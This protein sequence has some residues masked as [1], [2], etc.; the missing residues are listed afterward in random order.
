MRNALACR[1]AIGAVQA[2]GPHATALGRSGGLYELGFGF[3]SRTSTGVK[4]S[5]LVVADNG[6]GIPPDVLTRTLDFE[7]HHTTT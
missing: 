7:N 6:P 5:T 1:L 2:A 4:D 3:P